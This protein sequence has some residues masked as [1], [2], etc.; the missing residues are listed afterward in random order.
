M[1]ENVQKK[2]SQKMS[3]FEKFTFASGDLFGGGAQVIVS[4]YYLIFLTDIVRIRPG[5]AGL[6]ILL[7]KVWDAVSD[8]LM[9]IITDNTKT[10]FGRRK[11]YFLAGFFAVIAAF[12]LL[13]YPVGFESELGRFAFVLFAYLFYSTVSTMVMVPYSA[14]S[15]EISTDYKERNVVNGMRLF[16][17]QTS[18]LFCAVL[19][20]EI[21]KLFENEAHGY[22]AMAVVLSIFFAIPYLMI[23]LFCKE[24]VH[25]T[26]ETS[27]FSIKSMAEPFK[28]KSFRILVGI[29]LFAFL[30]MDIV[31]TTFAYYMNYYLL[32]PNEL[33]YVLGA[34]LITQIVLVPVVIHFSN[35]IG[36]AKTLMV[37]IS[38][39]LLSVF[40]MFL[41]TPNWPSYSIYVVAT[42][43]GMGLIGCIVIPWIMYPDVTDVGE[44]AFKRRNS[45]SFSGVMTFM[46]KFS[47]AIGIFIV[48]QILDF[49]GYLKPQT[50]LVD[51]VTH[52]ILMVQPD[53][54]ILAL[55]GI[56]IVLPILLLSTTFFLAKKYPLS[57][58]V[59]SKLSKQLAFN[60]G[61][62][63]V[64]LPEGELEALKKLLI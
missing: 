5:L 51:G 17:S 20:I 39:W 30:S 34:M 59:H 58:D 25:A 21:V 7:S 23:F 13:W 26:S 32:R 10:R 40:M 28:V 48:S 3:A 31:S 8:P 43:M 38:I 47:S 52:K 41:V 27:T 37:S 42:V 54:V 22:I 57:F 9:G 63:A 49:S 62:A 2:A 44:L 46:R 64:G 14:M 4:F 24:R 11:P 53:S 29:Y 18:S 50:E 61:E 33:N 19:P 56:V 36:K 12:I 45:G 55:R 15:S 1:G 16:F 35:K 60:R 6:I